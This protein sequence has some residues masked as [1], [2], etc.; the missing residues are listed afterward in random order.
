MQDTIEAEAATGDDA[1]GPAPP[2]PPLPPLVELVDIMLLGVSFR[3]GGRGGDSGDGGGCAAVAPVATAVCGDGGGVL[4]PAKVLLGL[5]LAAALAAD[6]T[7]V[8][9]SAAVV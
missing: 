9:S 6:A 8:G 5:P 2:P 1:L 3:P 4:T 7:S